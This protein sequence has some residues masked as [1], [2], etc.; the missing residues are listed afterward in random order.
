MWYPLADLHDRNSKEVVASD[1]QSVV[2]LILVQNQVLRSGFPVG[3]ASPLVR[4]ERPFV[5]GTNAKSDP[6]L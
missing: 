2:P 3:N 5:V 6:R 1:I 4:I